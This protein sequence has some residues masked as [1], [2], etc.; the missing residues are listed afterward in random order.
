VDDD[1]AEGLWHG[2]NEARFQ[3]FGFD[4]GR[5]WGVAPGWV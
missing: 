4:C 5:S 1:L 2:G 3:R